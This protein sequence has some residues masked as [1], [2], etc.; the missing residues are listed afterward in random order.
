MEPIGETIR[1]Q[2]NNEVIALQRTRLHTGFVAVEPIAIGL[3]RQV[4]A[5]CRAGWHD[6]KATADDRTPVAC[7]VLRLD[8][9]DMEPVGETVRRQIHDEVITL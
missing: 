5:T 2:I 6:G 9:Q 4:A 7:I 8:V 1:R 3:T